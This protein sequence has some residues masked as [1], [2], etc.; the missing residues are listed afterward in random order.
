MQPNPEP[1]A[2][3]IDRPKTFEEM[4]A[5]RG[6]QAPLDHAEHALKAVL[7]DYR[8]QQQAPCGLKACRKLHNTGFLVITESGAETNIGQFCGR[9]HFGEEV[10]Q[11][12]RADHQRL[13]D[14]A[15]LLKRAKDLQAATPAIV[16]HIKDLGYV[17]T[18]GAKWAT[19][20]KTEI[21]GVIGHP[22]VDA[23]EGMQ[24]RRDFEVKEYRQRTDKEIED[25]MAVNKGLTRA[26]ARDATAVIGT[27]EPMPWI[28]FDFRQRLMGE[29]M[30]PLQAFAEMKPDDLPTP[31][32]RSVLKP[33]EG[34]AQ[35]LQEAE[36][37]AVSA[38]RFLG[39][40]NLRLVALWFPE[41]HKDRAD[42]L[43]KWIGS[44]KHKTLMTGV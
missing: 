34:H 1:T 2:S 27:L 24:G 8:F 26:Q 11:A 5:R 20:V 3:L 10:F 18:F 23:L 22:L 39:D 13:R 21:A 29:L 25:L 31:K 12:A 6:F 40:E 15:D 37:A 9:T 44:T 43:R 7:S 41:H 42:A 38:I 14:R 16:A 35:V 32:L 28:N 33:I 36:E 17:R 19:K 30:L 4:S